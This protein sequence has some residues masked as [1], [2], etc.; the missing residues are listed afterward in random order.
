VI[1]TIL[2][3]PLLSILILLFIKDRKILAIVSFLVT[4]ITFFVSL[5]LYFN[6]DFNKI[7]FQHIESVRV[8]AIS[9]W[10]ILLTTFLFPL[11]VAGAYT[12]I[13]DKFRGYYI[14]LMILE[15][16][17]IGAFAALDLFLFYIFWEL[18]LIPMFFI[19]GLWGGKNRIY[20]TIKFVLFT[21]LGSL[22][23]LVAIIYIG[24]FYKTIQYPKDC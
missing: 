9:L 24:M 17:I 8:D 23:M 18:M 10:M 15:S 14:S 21:M 12:S 13:N 7:G 19:I 16:S 3:I 11:V 2:L 22:L 6:F 5:Q 4:L 1:T 20:A